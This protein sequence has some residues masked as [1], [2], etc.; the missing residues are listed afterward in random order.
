MPTPGFYPQGEQWPGG[1]GFVPPQ[2]RSRKVLFLSL[3]AVAAVAVLV[4]G[5]V[6]VFSGGG[7]STDGAKTAGAAVKGY[8]EAL[9]RGDAAAALSYG[10]ASIPDKTFLTDD[11]LQ[12]QAEKYP[13]TNIEIL[14]ESGNNVKV[15][16]EIG[17]K[18]SEESV[19]LPTPSEG[20]GWKLE[21]AAVTVDLGSSSIYSPKLMKSASLFG[22]PIPDADKVYAFPGWLDVG[23]SNPNIDVSGNSPDSSQSLDYLNYPKSLLFFDMK[24]SKTGLEAVR[25][26]L[27]VL[28]DECVKS[29]QLAPPNCPQ[30]AGSRTDLVEG[31]AQWTAPSNYDDIEIGFFNSQDGTASISGELVF[32]VTVQTTSGAPDTGTLRRYVFGD[33]DMTQTPPKIK[34]KN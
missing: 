4:V 25:N 3:G 1:G 17:G 21:S 14:S 28:V 32:T 8:L 5:G 16:A 23:S 26:S 18:K 7:S 34:L 15:S 27:K 33:A 19:K 13:I 20:K 10:A 30:D 24:I 31:T 22:K 9:A 12:K 11:I 2:R 29:K 6:L